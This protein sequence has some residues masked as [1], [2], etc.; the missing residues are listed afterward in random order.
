MKREKM[1]IYTHMF[2]AGFIAAYPA[3]SRAEPAHHQGGAATVRSGQLPDRPWEG[4]SGDWRGWIF[5]SYLTS[6]SSYDASGARKALD[7]NGRFTN[8]GLNLFGEYSLT[9]RWSLSAFL[10]LQRS[11][12]ANDLQN[13]GWTS[14][15]DVYGWARYRFNDIKGFSPAVLM[16]AKVPGNYKVVSGFGDGQVDYEVQG[17]LTKSLKSGTYIAANSGY[18]YRQ[19]G[20]A[21]EIIFGGQLGLAPAQGWLL[22]PS[23]NGV[24]GAGSGVQKDFLNAGFSVQKAISGPWNFLAFYNRILSGKNIVS[25]DV[26]SL[27]ISFR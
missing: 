16:G 25:A 2:L 20:I 23:L 19:G 7:N 11:N 13:D 12:L 17:F 6:G 4:K 9:S 22:I 21:D 5:G 15:G 10:P 26:W 8:R 3:A 14:L 1:R 27:G 24:R 18:R